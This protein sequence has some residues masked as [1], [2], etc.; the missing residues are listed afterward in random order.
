MGKKKRKPIDLAREAAL[1]GDV[2]TA[3]PLL[4]ECAG[5]GDDSAAASLAEVLAF[6][7]QWQECL[8][9]AARLIANPFAVYSANV[10]NDMVRLLGRAGHET[11]SWDAVAAAA[12]NARRQVEQ[13]LQTNEMQF[14][15]VKVQAERTRLDAILERLLEDAR[16][17]GTPAEGTDGE[18][19]R[20]FSAGPASGPD[21]ASYRDALAKNKGKPPARLLDLA[22]VFLI[23][24][25]AIRLFPTVASPSFEQAVFVAQALLRQGDPDKAWE[26]IA[27]HVA[28]WCPVDPAQV[29]PVVLLTDPLLRQITTPERA[30]SVIRSPR[31][32]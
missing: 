22:I 31:G 8:S 15:D 10:F 32:R 7:G 20:I 21:E 12:G 3:L 4:S 16:S 27:G 2:A 19:I 26:T 17:R 6:L 29:A 23:D 24:A 5:Q 11:G 1:Q 28:D 13:R 30:L 14:P 18:L 9:N 25:E